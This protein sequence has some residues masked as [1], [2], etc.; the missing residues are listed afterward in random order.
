MCTRTGLPTQKPQNTSPPLLGAQL[1]D[2]HAEPLEILTHLHAELLEI[3]ADMGTEL[4]E[5]VPQRIWG[6]V[7]HG[8]NVPQ[9]G[10]RGRGLALARSR[11]L[12]FARGRGFFVFL[13]PRGHG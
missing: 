3:L 10:P 8:R 9:I 5:A 12:P 1:L 2:L 7:G 4:L 6:P 11:R 13:G